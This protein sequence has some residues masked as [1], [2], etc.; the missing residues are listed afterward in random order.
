MSDEYRMEPFVCAMCGNCCRG[1]GFVRIT[2]GDAEKI[3][4]FLGLP[5]PDF[6]AQ[7][8]RPA[9]IREHEEAG[10]VWLIDKPGP[11]MECV[12]LE[13][14]RCAINPAKP[15]QCIGFPTKWRTPD[16]L[17]YCVGMQRQD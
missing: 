14:N 3:A 7:F 4:A 2:P 6:L 16:I 15:D 8:T 11:E 12:F 10:D 1:D 13:H 5:L 9:E 17:D